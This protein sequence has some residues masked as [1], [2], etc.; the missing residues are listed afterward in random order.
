MTNPKIQGEVS[1]DTSNAEAAFARVDAGASKMA[2]GVQ[3][4]ADKAGKS[5][6]GIGDGADASAQKLD[7]S[8]KSIIGSVQRATAVLEAGERGSTKYFEALANQ[9]GANIDALRPYL[10]QLEEV[11]RKQDAAGA[12]LGSMG[13]SAKQT[14]AAMRGVP[15][16]F[17][18]I[19]T[20]LQG[21]QAP[22]TVLLQQGG[23]LKDMFG[24]AGGAAKALGGYVLGIINPFTLAAAAVGGLAYAYSQGSAEAD[25]YAKALILTGNAAGTTVGKLAA[26]A[27]RI[28][29]VSGSQANAAEA[30]ATFAGSAKV[31]ASNMEAF[32]LAAIRFERT[33]GQAVGD[34]AKQ[35]AD[36]AKD[37]LTA[38]LK[39]NEGMN[40]LTA[41]TYQQIKA[42]TDQGRATDAANVAQKA[43]A[44]TLADRSGEM[45][46]RLGV[47]ERAWLGI[48]D[49][50]SGA[51]SAIAGI[52]RGGSDIDSK[53]A[54]ARQKL[55]NA[56]VR[57]VDK[58]EVL[59]QGRSGGR[60]VNR[61]VEAEAEL[62][63]LLAQKRTE[64]ELAASRAKSA[65]QTK[66]RAEADKD[67]AKY[68][69]DQ[70][71]LQA[72]LTRQ[73]AT[74]RAAGAGQDEIAARE[75]AIR[76]EFAKK[77][78]KS[79]EIK[80]AESDLARYS[81]LVADLDGKGKGL[82]AE[83]NNQA[84]IL[85]KGWRLSG[86]SV[87]VYNRALEQLKAKQP[88]VVEAE[89]KWA[90]ERK[91]RY[92]DIQSQAEK[93]STAAQQSS[94]GV[95]SRI[96]AM[97]DEEAA[98]ERSRLLNISLAAALEDVRIARLND[99]IAKAKLTGD[100]EHIDALQAE[101][102]A[103]TKLA[104]LTDRKT[105]RDDANSE[106]GD[107]L[108]SGVGADFGAGFDKASQSMGVF[109]GTFGKLIDAQ[110]K[111]NKARAD[112]SLSSK[113]MGKAE[114]AFQRQQ[115]SGY[116]S[117]AGAAKGFF[118]E[119]TAGYK[120]LQAAEQGLRAAE[121]AS[122]IASISQSL[123]VGQAKAVAGVANQAGGDPY[124]AFP[125]I[126]A[127]VGIMAALGF[128]V[129]GGSSGGGGGV[130]A[131]D[132]QATQGTGTVFGDSKAKSE[133]IKNSI[134]LLKDVDTLTMQYSGQML[135][136]LRNIESALAGVTGQIIR[137]GGRVTGVSFSGS[138]TFSPAVGFSDK[139]LQRTASG[140]LDRVLLGGVVS[141]MANRLSKAIFGSTKT[142]LQ[143]AGLQFG[144]GSLQDVLGGGV[145]ATGY[146]STQTVKKKLFGL[147]KQTSY[148]TSSFGLDPNL[149]NQFTNVIKDTYSGVVAATEALGTSADATKAKLAGFNVEL[150]RIS[151]M[152]LSGDKIQ[153]QLE[154]VFGSF[155]DKLAMAA[156]A[157]LGDFQKAGE[158]YFET[159]VRVS[160]GVE[161]ASSTLKKLGV[162][163]I[164]LADL[165]RK[166]GDVSAELV[167][168]SAQAKEG[169]SGIADILGVIDGSAQ[170]IASAYTSLAEARTNFNLV[171]LDGNAIT[172]SLIGGAGGLQELTDSLKAFEDGFVDSGDKID[173]EAKRVSI[174]F[175]RL[176]LALPKSGADFVALVKGINTSTDA[177][178]ELL[179]GLLGLSDGFSSLLGAIKDAGSGITDE[180]ERIKGLTESSA[181]KTLPELQSSFA[182]KT[183]QARAG[184]QSAIDLLP[185]IS[186]ALLKAAEATAGSSL[187]V[188]VIQARTLASLQATL[189]VI[190]DPTKRLGTLPGF[191]SGGYFSGGYRVVGE[192]GPEIEATGP[193]RIF[194]SRQTARILSNTG[195]DDVIAELRALRS[196]VAAL[197]DESRDDARAIERNT[198]RALQLWEAV[199]PDGNSISTVAA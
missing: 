100:Q 165:E 197:R 136:S 74:L 14:A 184:D 131:A 176:G 191:A 102:T 65:A 153:E 68:L 134:D 174:Q 186:Q 127:M 50:A 158:G 1:L 85:Q 83:F 124:T 31:G 84:A 56:S 41:S 25:A 154:A 141:N 51:V 129:A 92:D 196:E 53:I 170:D 199:T 42:L 16:Q 114:A 80:L 67:G 118:S 187:D 179:G 132:Q 64:E 177:G 192:S 26:M 110:T 61:R 168:Q 54:E 138:E 73:T 79:P 77:D 87:D 27:D 198:G 48:K 147:S 104:A 76:A 135:A 66:A 133:S 146:E 149:T 183:A 37:P 22:L 125:R 8:T 70:F 59:P 11:K 109:V 172:L 49:A 160:S 57:G 18:D 99:G 6:N 108:K 4:S 55:A 3:K 137:S 169:L 47:V 182:I 69:N 173:N 19:I 23:Q 2:A 86:D 52:G 33:A 39:L 60:T 148:A 167:R 82:S 9:R 34:T 28:G 121:L 144:A 194:D 17:T 155:A 43:F 157:S 107:L 88:G 181:A 175:E 126:A 32:T 29:G 12:S 156:D 63:V 13:I 185:S 112:T 91:K 94:K 20:S 193:S 71:K 139:V 75:K 113:D 38:S 5:V 106:L 21:G 105:A 143:D 123:A 58:V 36:L 122:S 188:A 119:K 115:I 195:S 128:A 24:G 44:D 72:E 130:S 30:L 35:F 189:E 142:T 161:V 116:A 140:M 159:L 95:E 117:L 103:R 89:K 7:R 90:D 111:Y 62:A 145:G 162:E 164:A 10:A 180:I 46:K 163:A 152:G 15:A 150:G 93:E 97:Q 171:G 101:I 166:Q 98:I 120:V 178:Q 45:E 78:R 96:Q 40:Y 190:S 81:D 151:L